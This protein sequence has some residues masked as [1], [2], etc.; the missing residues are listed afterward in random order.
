MYMDGTILYG[1]EDIMRQGK[2]CEDKGDQAAA[3]KYV[4]EARDWYIKAELEYEKAYK[5][6]EGYDDYSRKQEAYACQREAAY[7]KANVVYSDFSL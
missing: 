3:Q 6:A 7:K 5:Y 1:F 4:Y 2:W